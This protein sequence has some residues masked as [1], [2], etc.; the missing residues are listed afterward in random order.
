VW[1]NLDFNASIYTLN[2]YLL[3]NGQA[4]ITDIFEES[5]IGYTVYERMKSSIPRRRK[6]C[7]TNICFFARGTGPIQAAE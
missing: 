4:I 2:E 1:L 3:L 6:T 5:N 7:Y